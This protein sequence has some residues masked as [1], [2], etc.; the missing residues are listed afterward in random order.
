MQK[1]LLSIA[2]VTSLLT[3]NLHAVEESKSIHEK[4][5]SLLKLYDNYISEVM[6]LDGDGL[7]PRKNRKKLW[8]ELAK[9]LR[10]QLVRAKTKMEI[11]R[12]F[13][14]LDAG[15]TNLHAHID[16]NKDYDYNSEGRPVFAANFRPEKV[17]ASGS[18]ARYLISSVKK[19]Y[20]IHLEP[21]E[22]P[23]AGDEVLAINDR[24]LKNWSKENF[25]YCKFPLRSQCEMDFFDNFRKGMLSW[26]RRQKLI[27]TIA[28]NNKKIKVQIPVFA[29]LE[30]KKNESGPADKMDACGENSVRYPE[31]KLVYQGFHAC[32]YE[33]QSKKDLAILRIRSFK[34]RGVND[35]TKLNDIYKETSAFYDNY[36]KDRSNKMKT[37]VF[38]LVE[39]YGGD[40]VVTWSNQF[41]DGPFQDQWVQFKNIKEL[42]DVNWQKSAFYDD[43]GKFQVLHSF[44]KTKLSEN[45]FLP[46]MPQ[47]C[48]SDTDCLKEKWRPVDHHFSGNV[49]MITDQ[50]C[51][52]SCTGFAW[53]I[54][55]YL[56]ERVKVIGMPESGDSTYSRAYISGSLLDSNGHMVEVSPRVPGPRVEAKN[57]SIFTQAVSVS[58]STD[59]FSNVLSGIP[60]KVD[61]FD[62]PKW[63]EDV[64]TWVG[65]LVKTYL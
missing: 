62:A 6:R 64:D 20:F 42:S 13:A 49:V 12:V 60:V 30:S 17:E 38:D 23:S 10:A 54:K 9:D 65:R 29:K 57:N 63:D 50:W 33:S 61:I 31:F 24:S 55:H 37:I 32:A 25:E 47:F 34:Y 35:Q 3:F 21:E 5:S 4:K 14:R 22:R 46:P 11:G 8:K 43:Q 45:S 44:E 40:T 27:F 16:L 48:A 41:I 59:E 56:G 58:R 7:I 15:Y 1:K 18:V 2:V 39:N 19:E 53:T 51:I 26:N 52:S 28:H 36:W